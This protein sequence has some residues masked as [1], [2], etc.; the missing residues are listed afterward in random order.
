MGNLCFLFELEE[1]SHFLVSVFVY[2]FSNGQVIWGLRSGLRVR[3]CGHFYPFMT[4]ISYET[5]E[6]SSEFS[7]SAV[8]AVKWEQQCSIILL[9]TSKPMGVVSWLHSTNCLSN[10][11]WSLWTHRSSISLMYCFWNKRG[12]FL[13]CVLLTSVTCHVCPG[14][15]WLDVIYGH[16]VENEILTVFTDSYISACI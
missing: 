4:L 5:S 15:F 10:Y 14:L 1:P 7:V 12:L 16:F 11:L 13:K 9:S 6:K 2:K 3:S 8:P